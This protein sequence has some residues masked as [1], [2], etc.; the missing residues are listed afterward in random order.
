MTRDHELR[1]RLVDLDLDRGLTLELE[2]AR[3]GVSNTLPARGPKRES[4]LR[5]VALSNVLALEE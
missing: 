3:R 2:A 1:G 5:Q 4:S